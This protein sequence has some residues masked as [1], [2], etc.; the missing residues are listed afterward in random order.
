LWPAE[1][2]STGRSCPTLRGLDR[3]AWLSESELRVGLG[4]MRLST[5]E[6]RDEELALETVAAAVEAGVTVFDTARAY[7]LGEQ[8]L[9]H[10]ERLLARALRLCRG[11]GAA[12]IVTKG[13][14]TRPGGAWVPDG[15][16]KTIRSDCEA[17]LAALDG[18]PIDLFLVHA[19][20]PRTPWRTTVRALARLV[21]EGLARRVGV[22]NVSRP[23]LDEAL[24]HAPLAAVQVVLSPFDDRAR[25]G[26]V[27]DR[28]AESGI[29]VIAYS[30]L[31]GPRRKG[32][33][34]RHL[35]LGEVAAARG[36]TPA[37]AAIAWVLDVSPAVV[38]IP[39]ARRPEAARSAAR[40]ARLELRD[41]DRAVLA[42]MLGPP[43]A[44]PAR[45]RAE[46]VLVMGIP[47]AGKSRVAAGYVDQGYARL[48]RDERGGSLRELAAA[49]DERLATG[50]RKLVL[51]NTYLTRASR[52]H[53]VEVAARHGA[54]VECIWLDTSLAQAQVNLVERLLERLGSLPGPDELRSLARREPGLLAPTSQMRAR[55]EL[56]P[57]ADDEGFAR[58]RRLPFERERREG[59]TRAGVFVARSALERPGWVQALAGAVPGAP[60]LLFD[61]S[62]GGDAVN[63]GPDA[64]R[65][66]AMVAGHVETALCPHGGGPPRCWCRP[67][68]P[69]LPLAFARAH[70]VDP[71]ASLLVG[72]SPAHRTLADTLGA[73]FLAP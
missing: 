67:P 20:D 16:A 36:V 44:R 73:R 27:V 49:L 40:A 30:P 63:L 38:A 11:E 31:G 10:N 37:E 42:R 59:R 68:L 5:D 7:G 33:L 43:T 48:N 60:S 29:A 4:C 72:T 21:D 9:G 71:G 19:P 70:D 58:V 46:V 45:T 54:A 6:G 35:Q 26:G 15:R 32:A 1:R 51:D 17:S 8:D 62:P 69:G 23:Q 41:E 52:S 34:A 39:G 61:W 56:E 12:R 50:A 28:C 57:P 64:A 22:A 53:V 47:G 25:R 18:L 66:S 65:L 24:A 14:M 55:R 3:P 2:E 13:G